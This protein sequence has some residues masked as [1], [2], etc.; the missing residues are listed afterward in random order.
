M[1]REEGGTAASDEIRRQID[2]WTLIPINHNSHRAG[3]IISCAGRCHVWEICRNNFSLQCNGEERKLRRCIICVVAW[4]RWRYLATGAG[5]EMS[6]SCKSFPRLWGSPV[7]FLWLH[8]LETKLQSAKRSFYVFPLHIKVTALLSFAL[9]PWQK[10]VGVFFQSPQPSIVIYLICSLSYWWTVQSSN[11]HVWV[12][13]H[14]HQ[15]K[16]PHSFTS[17]LINNHHWDMKIATRS[18]FHP[19][20]VAPHQYRGCRN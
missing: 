11:S 3:I 17:S 9:H 1:P 12:F 14:W 8:L 6:C 15:P 19:L 13:G 18:P 4:P 5:R 16:H 10:H 2:Q 7:P 20:C